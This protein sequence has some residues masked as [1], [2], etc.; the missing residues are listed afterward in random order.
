MF[1]KSPSFLGTGIWDS[2]QGC[3]P[4]LR[5]WGKH[6]SLHLRGLAQRRRSAAECGPVD[7]SQHTQSRGISP[8]DLA[9]PCRPGLAQLTLGDAAFSPEHTPLT[10]VPPTGPPSPMDELCVLVTQL[11]PSLCNPM[12]CARPRDPTHVSCCLCL[13][14]WQAGSSPL[15]PPGKP[16]IHT[17][18]RKK[19][20]VA[21]L[22][23]TLC[24]PMDCI[25]HQAPLSMEFSKQEYWSG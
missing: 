13:L 22:C 14:H 23:L 1:K 15:A 17:Y 12:D 9:I 8:V 11:C 19:V 25:A 2:N 4:T 7:S 20:K 18:T 21:L 5:L 24:D 6:F 10:P 16:R 3:F